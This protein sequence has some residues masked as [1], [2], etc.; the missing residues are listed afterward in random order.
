MSIEQEA[1][2]EALKRENRG[3]F[4]IVKYIAPANYFGADGKMPI[5]I[6]EHEVSGN[7]TRDWLPLDPQR[8]P[9]VGSQVF[10]DPQITK[11]GKGF[12]VTYDIVF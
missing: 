4:G 6:I 12:G 10:V 2:F 7:K 9:E 5:A 3:Y 1:R 11:V 8:F